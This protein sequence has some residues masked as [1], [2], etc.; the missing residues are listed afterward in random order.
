MALS[1][2]T[3][4]AAI[5]AQR[6]MGRN[7]SLDQSFRRL[8]AEARADVVDESGPGQS[9]VSGI[10]TEIR[11]RNQVLRDIN[12]GLSMAHVVDAALSSSLDILSQLRELLAGGREKEE[13]FRLLLAELDRVSHEAHFNGVVGLPHLTDDLQ[14]L[15]AHANV[16]TATPLSV[17]IGRVDVAGLGLSAAN[18]EMEQQGDD[19]TFM[20][21]I[22]AALTRMGEARRKMQ[23]IQGRFEQVL[24]SF[25]TVSEN[26]AS[27]RSRNDDTVVAAS[28]SA[29]ARHA[30]LNQVGTAIQA[31]ANQ[32]AQ[33]VVQLLD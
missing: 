28:T 22:D 15:V 11:L 19:P 4:V 5:F 13:A 30:I 27:A 2:Q 3:N 31:Q 29:M 1:I 21:R 32:P 9:L 23:A 14:R 8:A 24:S 17:Q 26:V 20:Q 33:L 10:Y 7:S 6:R 12:D 18:M 25:A 16:D